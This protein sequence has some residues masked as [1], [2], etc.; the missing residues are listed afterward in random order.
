MTNDSDPLE[1]F[2]H[3]QIQKLQNVIEYLE[4]RELG[5]RPSG[6]DVQARADESF[7]LL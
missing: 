3:P 5:L 1:F 7:K 2:F 6:A 4:Q